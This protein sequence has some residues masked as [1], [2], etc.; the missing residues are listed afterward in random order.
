MQIPRELLG[1]KQT[2]NSRTPDGRKAGESCTLSADAPSSQD[3]ESAASVERWKVFFR[4]SL[5]SLR[6]LRTVVL[7]ESLLF[8]VTVLAI[9]LASQVLPCPFNHFSHFSL[10]S[11]QF[12]LLFPHKW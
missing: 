1:Q 12:L 10:L 5:T 3:P 8:S 6:A 11:F 4:A 7:P 9:A 2:F